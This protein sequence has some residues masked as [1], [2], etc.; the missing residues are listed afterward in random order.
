MLYIDIYFYWVIITMETRAVANEKGCIVTQVFVIFISFCRHTDFH[1]SKRLF[2]VSLFFA[3]SFTEGQIHEHALN[4]L[5]Y[6]HF[7]ALLPLE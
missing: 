5:H 1:W 7:D 6:Y 4:Q 3:Q 2:F